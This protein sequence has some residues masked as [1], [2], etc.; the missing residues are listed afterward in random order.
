MMEQNQEIAARAQAL[1]NSRR[2][3]DGPKLT[4]RLE[5]ELDAHISFLHP[6]HTPVEKK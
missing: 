4:E 5:D 3:N 2:A 6:R 1:L